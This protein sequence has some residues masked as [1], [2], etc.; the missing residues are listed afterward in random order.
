LQLW[1][2][3]SFY[4][5]HCLQTTDRGCDRYGLIRPT[6]ALNIPPMK[7]NSRTDSNVFDATQADFEQKVLAAS[8]EI[9]VLVDFWAP[10]C[11]PCKQ[12]TPVLEKVVAGYGGRLRLAK[13]NTDEQMQL[14]A[15][16][17]IRSLP[18]VMLIKDG[19]PVDGFMGAQPESVI[20]ELLEAHLGPGAEVD[21]AL[22]LPTDP[23]QMV[24]TLREAIA[25]EPDKSELKLELA[26]ALMPLGDT[27]EVTRI[28]DALPANLAESDIARRLRSQLTF[29]RALKGAAPRNE[30]A[31]LVD[32]D[33]DNLKAR[34]QF[35]T[36]LL[37]DGEA[38]PA[39]EQ[40]LEIMRRDRQFEDDLGRKSLIAAFELVDDADLVSRTR[41]RM[42]SMLF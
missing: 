19:R 26:K 4:G 15:L 23:R 28:L 33:P 21:D 10:W 3:I 9:P 24:A 36:R 31:I 18:T 37:I 35:G 8:T 25:A 29:A 7:P 6:H 14:A 39:L 40:F 30:L 11:A 2:A 42:S 22:P 20:R 16:F 1:L 32:R 38:E 13:V 12:L 34:Y 27:D 17:G 41:R 5:P